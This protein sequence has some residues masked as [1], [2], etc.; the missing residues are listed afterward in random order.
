MKTN[1]PNKQTIRA[2]YIQDL[3]QRLRKFEVLGVQATLEVQ[4]AGRKVAVENTHLW[5]LLRLHG[6]SNQDLQEYMTA[7]IMNI[8]L[9]PFHSRAV[10]EARSHPWKAPSLNSV[11]EGFSQL[12]S[13]NRERKDLIHE[14]AATEPTSSL[15]S[16][17][18]NQ[19]RV[20]VDTPTHGT[21]KLQPP[22]RNQSSGQSTPCETVTGIITSISNC[23]VRN[24]D[25]FQLLDE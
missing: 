18:I 15:S 25:I 1:S 24:M 17:A 7:H 19:E 12:S 23:M 14:M 4:A 20:P 10:L 13:L 21:S 5:S 3:E 16:P 2:K 8:V 6:V 11:R 22:S 9:P